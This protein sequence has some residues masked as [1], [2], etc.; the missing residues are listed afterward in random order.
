MPDLSTSVAPFRG[1]MVLCSHVSGLEERPKAGG[2]V[3]DFGISV[4][5]PDIMWISGYH[6]TQQPRAGCKQSV[7]LSGMN[8]WDP[9]H[10]LASLSSF[11]HQMSWLDLN[12]L[13]NTVSYP[14]KF[15]GSYF[16][17]DFQPGH[18]ILTLSALTEDIC[19][20]NHLTPITSIESNNLYCES[21]P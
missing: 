21:Y 2:Q 12:T 10:E 6:C 16:V 18:G 1:R 17:P 8:I 20:L 11:S 7:R 9:R 19:Q 13:E 4:V 15:L 5:T 14:H 3:G